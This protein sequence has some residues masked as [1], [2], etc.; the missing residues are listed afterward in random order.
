MAVSLFLR[1]PYLSQHTCLCMSKDPEEL[2]REAFLER[3]KEAEEQAAKAVEAAIREN[4]LK[5][6][7]GYRDLARKR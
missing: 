7:E 1:K 2:R 4:W 3:A 5:V 6:A